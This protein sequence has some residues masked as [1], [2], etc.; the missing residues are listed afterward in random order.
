[1]VEEIYDVKFD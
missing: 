1:L